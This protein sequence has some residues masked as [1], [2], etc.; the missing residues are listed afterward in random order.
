MS[1]QITDRSHSGC[2]S[3]IVVGSWEVLYFSLL[4][5]TSWSEVSLV[6]ARVWR[7]FCCRR[8]ERELQVRLTAR[9]EPIN[10]A[11]KS[12]QISYKKPS[13]SGSGKK[14]VDIASWSHPIYSRSRSS[15][16]GNRL[17]YTKKWWALFSP[18]LEK[19]NNSTAS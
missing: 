13:Y 16:Q 12:S 15:W 17:H 4:W 3:L 1:K 8:E 19:C 11:S 9:C 18:V 5:S 6:W 14:E 10:L 2:C 7:L